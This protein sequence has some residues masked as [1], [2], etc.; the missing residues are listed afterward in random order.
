MTT[1]EQALIDIIE[2]I[3]EATQEEL[4]KIDMLRLIRDVKAIAVDAMENKP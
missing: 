1:H 2:L 4:S 3:G